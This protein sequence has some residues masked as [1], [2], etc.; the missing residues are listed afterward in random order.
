[1]LLKCI[2][3]FSFCIAIML[4]IWFYDFLFI[5]LNFKFEFVF[6]FSKFGIRCYFKVRFDLNRCEVI[7]SFYFNCCEYL[8]VLL[9]ILMDLIIG[10]LYNLI[11]MILMFC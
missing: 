1:M 3:I 8:L 4:N 2:I 9:R 11:S 10:V 6:F 5:I 7:C